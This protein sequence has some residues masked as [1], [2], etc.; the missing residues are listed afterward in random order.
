MAQL[1]SLPSAPVVPPQN[2][3]AEESVLG[4]MLLSPGA[5][6]AVTEVLSAGD[7]YR[8]S[9][10]IIFRACLA[11]YQQGEPVDAITLVDALEERGELEQVG[12]RTKIGELVG[13]GVVLEPVADQLRQAGVGL[14]HDSTPVRPAWVSCSA[15]ACISPGPRPQLAP[16][17]STPSAA[18]V[19]TASAGRTP[20]IV[21]RSASKLRVA[22]TGT[23]GYHCR[24]ASTAASTR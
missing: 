4:A 3:E 20:I 22:M 14:G 1:A 23:P 2:L 7:F 10:G 12:G 6:G 15:M 21:R 11:L 13:R 24:A 18:S 9:H 5:I 17:A 8:E 16:T 19:V